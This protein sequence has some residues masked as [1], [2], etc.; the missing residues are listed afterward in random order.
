MPRDGVR[1]AIV[2]VATDGLRDFVIMPDGQR[3]LL[4][5]VSVLKFVTEL[6]QPLGHARRVLNSFLASG[7]ATFSADLDGMAEL[8]KPIVARWS[9]T[10]TGE[11]PPVDP[12]IPG[13]DRTSSSSEGRKVMADVKTL[14]ERLGHIEGVVTLLDKRA[15]ESLIAPKLHHELRSLVGGLHFYNPGDQ[16]KNNA[17]YTEGGKVDTV[18]GNVSLPSS[19]THS[20]ALGIKVETADAPSSTPVNA[21]EPSTSTVYAPGTKSASAAAP[22]SALSASPSFD[23]FKQN[24]MLAEDVIQTVETT[25]QKVDALVTAGRKFNAGKVKGELFTIASRVTEIINNVD[26][27]QPW[28]RNDLTALAA[29]AK[30]IHGLFASA[31]V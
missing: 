29:Q 10:S 23:N 15:G 18:D 21:P 31:K 2:T 6:C 16:S 7:S 13:V 5:P 8:L 4:G 3:M 27:A 11:T 28:V 19:A 1:K 22:A 25:D 30:H 17:W 24:T 9:S 26:L 14:L 20:T 12:L